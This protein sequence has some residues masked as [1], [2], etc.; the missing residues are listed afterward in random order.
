MDRTKEVF[1]LVAANMERG[2]RNNMRKTING[3]VAV[4]KT[5]KCDGYRARLRRFGCLLYT[6][7]SPRD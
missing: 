2:A 7:P 5:L 6:S 1:G 4:H 3:V